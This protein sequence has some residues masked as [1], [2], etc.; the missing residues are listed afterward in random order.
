[1]ITKILG[2]PFGLGAFGLGAADT[3]LLNTVG[4]MLAP[5]ANAAPVSP[6]LLINSRRFIV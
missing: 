1:M 4:D 2:R 3:C 5:P 6:T